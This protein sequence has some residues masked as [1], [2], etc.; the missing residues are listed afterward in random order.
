ML[1]TIRNSLTKLKDGQKQVSHREEGA[2]SAGNRVHAEGVRVGALVGLLVQAD[3][4][5]DHDTDVAQRRSNQ[6]H[7]ERTTLVDE[8]SRRSDE[9]KASDGSRDRPDDGWRAFANPLDDHPSEAAGRSAQVGDQQ[10]HARTC[11]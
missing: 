6:T 1:E 10:C 4:V 3:A 2:D 8:A 5:L 11:T 9:N 7:H